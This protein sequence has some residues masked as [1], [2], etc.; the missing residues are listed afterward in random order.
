MPPLK[1][2]RI[3]ATPQLTKPSPASGGGAPP[4][5]PRLL[6]KLGGTAE[7]RARFLKVMQR[8]P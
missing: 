3:Y 5:P 7:S 4:L 1:R 6:Q 2:E 8:M